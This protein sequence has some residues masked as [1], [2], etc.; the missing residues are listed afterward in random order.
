VKI[1]IVSNLFPPSA[2]GGYELNCSNMTREL[3]A[4]G[5]DV[6]VATSPSQV[7]GDP[8]PPYIRR[9]LVMAAHMPGYHRAPAGQHT[10]DISSFQNVAALREL[11]IAFRPEVVFLWNTHGIC[12]LHLIDFLNVHDVPWCIYL[13]D[14]VF[15]RMVNAAPA[16]V[17]AV[18]RGDDP[19]W[20]ASGGIMS[21]SQHL[22]D[23]IESV[24]RFTFPTPPVIVHG[25]ASP[26][27]PVPVRPDRRGRTLRFM[28]A[29]RVSEHKGTGL[30]CDAAALL[31]RS[32]VDDFVLDIYGDGEVAFYV[33]YVHSL[34]VADRVAF[35]GAAPQAELHR[36]F[37]LHDMFLFPTWSREPFAFVPFEAAAYGCVPILT[38]DCGCA[39]RIVDGVHGI[40]IE[41]TAKALADA[42][43]MAVQGEADLD[44]MAVASAAMVR[45]DLS[46][47]GHADKI[48]QVLEAHRRP[49]SL[50]SVSDR[51]ALLLA[52][53][54]HHL[55]LALLAGACD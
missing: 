32:G 50:A 26:A 17:R 19:A 40:K 30:V 31:V 5:H 9:C 20:F 2:I 4:R 53:I 8:D 7:P 24:G 42:M 38:E 28:A 36:Q 14:C 3:R 1:L 34:G 11:L 13:G 47:G 33:S 10:T 44:R 54:K 48:L 49:W 52:F 22:V 29:G 12:T 43:R 15:E 18:F 51:R 46:I 39:E 27:A 21:V 45:S 55:S 37:G 23:E 16:Y 41:R 25:F 6:L 35:H